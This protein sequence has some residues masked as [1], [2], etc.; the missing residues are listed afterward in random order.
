MKMATKMNSSYTE[1]EGLWVIGQIIFIK[2]GISPAEYVAFVK[3][4]KLILIQN[5]K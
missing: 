3:L 5:M 2:R 1:N 4:S